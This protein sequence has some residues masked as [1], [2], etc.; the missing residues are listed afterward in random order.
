M[1]D[2]NP[3]FV[4]LLGTEDIGP[5]NGKPAGLTAADMEPFR[6]FALGHRIPAQPLPPRGR[7][8]AQCAAVDPG[9]C[10]SP[11]TRPRARGSSTPRRIGRGPAVRGPATSYPFGTAGGELGGVQP[12][13]PTSAEA[14]ALFNG[15]ADGSPHSDLKIPHLRNMYEKI[16]PRFG[17]LTNAQDPP[18]D[19][20]NGFGF[21]HDGSIPDLQTFLS[22]T[23]FNLTAPQVRDITMFM[24]FF[25]TGTRPAVGRNVTVPPGAPPTAPPPAEQL[26]TALISL[27]N[28][29]D[30][31]GHCDLVAS[32]ATPRASGAGT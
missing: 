29:A 6:Q 31:N 32:G 15:T 22:A 1:N 2:F 13:E 7:H 19:Q 20:K 8:A 28:A 21:T 10:R 17:S 26:L 23:V 4:G 9:P 12:G 25:P 5:I 18:A 11:A 14:A 24:M 30:P 27:G 16:G 3:A